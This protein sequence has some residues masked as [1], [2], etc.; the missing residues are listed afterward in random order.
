MNVEIAVIDTTDRGIQV[1]LG[2]DTPFWLPRHAPGLVWSAPPEIGDVVM[3]R[4][5]DWLCAKH[6]HLQALRYQRSMSFHQP[7]GF[8]PDK[9]EG[10]VPMAN[11]APRGALFRV[12]EGEKKN[13]KWPDYR[14]DLTIENVKWKLAGWVKTDKNGGKYLSIVAKLPDEPRQQPVQQKPAGGPTFADE[15]PFGPEVRG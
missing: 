7:S 11:D 13:D 4:V 9:A 6:Q 12:P 5:P 8:D 3:V 15:I 14:G 2:E 1:A 10:P